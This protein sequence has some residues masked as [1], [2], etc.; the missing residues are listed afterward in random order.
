[1]LE[2]N[3]ESLMTQVLWE[4]YTGKLPDAK[5]TDAKWAVRLLTMVGGENVGILK[6]N[7]DVLVQVG[8]A[9]DLQDLE[10]AVFT[11][12]AIAK[13]PTTTTAAAAAASSSSTKAAKANANAN[14][15]EKIPSKYPN[16]DKVTT[17]HNRSQ[18]NGNYYEMSVKLV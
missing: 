2:S 12:E 6:A 1:M 14:P 17:R 15:G 9:E 4:C 18:H 5:P 11:A 10:V 8:F 16:D 7:I 3:L 13:L